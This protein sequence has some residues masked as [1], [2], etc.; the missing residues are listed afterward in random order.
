MLEPRLA[1]KEIRLK[2][3]PLWNEIKRVVPSFRTESL[4]AKLPTCTEGGPRNVLFL[5][6]NSKEK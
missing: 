4:G 2:N 3:G 6:C 5:K 1:L